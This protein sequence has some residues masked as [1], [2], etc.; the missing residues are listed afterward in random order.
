MRSDLASTRSKMTQNAKIIVSNEKTL[1]NKINRLEAKVEAI[2]Q[3][4]GL[5]FEIRTECSDQAPP[6]IHYEC[7][8]LNKAP[9]NTF[10]SDLQ[11]VGFVKS[12]EWKKINY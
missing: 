3:G 5:G 6:K 4:L 8:R 9:K 11:K 2:A 12:G 7:V 1:L 10:H